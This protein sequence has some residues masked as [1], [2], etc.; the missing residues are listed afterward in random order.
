MQDLSEFFSGVD[1]DAQY[2]DQY[3]GETK[4]LKRLALG[5]GGAILDVCCGTGIVTVPLAETGLKTVGIDI[6]E[7]MLE[8]AREKGKDLDNLS[9]RLENALEFDLEQRFDLAIMTG[10]AFQGFLSDEE[11]RSLLSNIH[12]HLS[13][14][15]LLVFD[16]RLPGG[17]DLSLDDDFQ[18]WSTYTLPD[19]RL[20]HFFD[21]QARYD[22]EKGILYY[23]MK[24]EYSDGTHLNKTTRYSSINLKFTPIDDLLALVKESGFEV[25][26]TYKNWDL[27]PFEIGAANIVLELKKVN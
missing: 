24:R 23:E 20:V 9:F 5:Q 22:D 6:T 3:E 21:K 12:A 1:Y 19:G 10:N 11:V 27:E 14:G 18:L 13:P 4:Y 15:G 2:G 8:R 25:V 16:T 17:Y 7:A 26:N